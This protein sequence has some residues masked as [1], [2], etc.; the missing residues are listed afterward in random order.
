MST[1]PVLLVTG[2]LGYI[3]RH[4]LAQARGWTVHA[5]WFR[6]PPD[7][8]HPPG[9]PLPLGEGVGV[10]GRSSP[11]PSDPHP[12]PLPEGEG[13]NGSPTWHRLDICDAEAVT[14][15]V[16]Q[17][18]P[19]AILHTAYQFNTPA[20]ERVITEGTRHVAQAAAEVGAR[21]VHL[22]TD[23]VFDGRR[24]MYRE[25]DTPQPV[26]AYGRAKLV[27]EADVRRLTP[28]AA[29]V[30]TSLVYGFDPPDPR[31]AWVIETA[32]QG[33]AI[34]LFTDELRC[35]IYAPD[36][37]AAL[38]E[39]AAGDFAGP[40]HIAGPDV[41]SRYDFGVLLC[42]AV[43]V[44]PSPIQATPAAASG[45]VRPLDCTLDTTLA[46]GLL[47]TRLRG[48]REVLAERFPTSQVFSPRRHG[49]TDT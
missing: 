19:A 41:L 33:G 28:D 34:T 16:H 39:V 10:R 45:L 26:H 36:L 12:N 21:L 1:A 42:Q 44:D 8:T 18:R 11:R 15:L 5:T 49:G 29:I 38:L 40:L 43:G 47:R 9:S 2:G 20:M 25:T 32:R 37:A 23:V 22:S 17:V 3:G 24:G 13:I 14:A 48:V 6:T 35:P 31:T 30:R 46:R 27:S 4:V 7:L